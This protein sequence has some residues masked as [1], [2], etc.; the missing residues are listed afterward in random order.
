MSVF[1]KNSGALLAKVNPNIK[2]PEKD[3]KDPP[4]DAEKKANAL[5]AQDTGNPVANKF[6]SSNPAFDPNYELANLSESDLEKLDPKIL[7]VSLKGAG[8]DIT[9]ED[10]KAGPGRLVFLMKQTE[11]G[12]F[13]EAAEYVRNQGG[14]NALDAQGMSELMNIEMRKKFGQTAG[15][16][17]EQGVFEPIEGKE[18]EGVFGFLADQGIFLKGTNLRGQG[19]SPFTYSIDRRDKRF[20]DETF[21]GPQDSDRGYRIAEELRGF[22]DAD[23]S[24]YHMSIYGGATGGDTGRSLLARIQGDIQDISDFSSQY[25]KAF[26]ERFQDNTFEGG[27]IE[28]PLPQ[29]FKSAMSFANN[30]TTVR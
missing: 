3:K 29:K 14:L 7:A 9:D 30:Q 21:T 11:T 23:Q 1:G 13:D 8:V 4:G 19:T 15:R 16:I 10:I 27:E 2:D 6:K 12:P 20:A 24:Q 17:N 28:F 5:G 22:K 26:R 18:A 25:V